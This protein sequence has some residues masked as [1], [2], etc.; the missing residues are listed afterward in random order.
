MNVPG[1][2]KLHIW[3]GLVV[4]LVGTFVGGYAYTG[5]RAYHLE[6]ILVALLGFLLIVAGGTLAAY[7]QA[8]R[9]R[10]GG[11]PSQNDEDEEDEEDEGPSFLDRVK[12]QVTV[13]AASGTD[14]EEPRGEEPVEPVEATVKCPDCSNVFE[15]TGQAPFTATCPECG[16]EDT[17]EIPA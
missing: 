12:A 14:G 6:F 13:L 10:L 2:P 17:V 16:H 9:P 3:L 1:S 7:G 4:A 15:T 11:T 8:S 5:D